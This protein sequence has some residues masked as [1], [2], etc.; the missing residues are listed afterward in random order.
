MDAICLPKLPALKH[1]A[2]IDGTRSRA[3]R[4]ATG[5]QK[6]R[7]KRPFLATVV[8]RCSILPVKIIFGTY[9]ECTQNAFGYYFDDIQISEYIRREFEDI[10]EFGLI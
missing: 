7:Q 9:S 2:K 1:P 6:R 4:G 5:G 3:L 10:Q 8:P